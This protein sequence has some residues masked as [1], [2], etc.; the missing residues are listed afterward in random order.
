MKSD[1]EIAQHAKMKKITTI[2][3][4]IGLKPSEIEMYG[5]YKAKISF[6]AINRKD[7]NSQGKIIL[8]SAINPTPAGEGKSTTTI[9]LGDSLSK[10]GYKTMIALREPSLG[11][12]MGVKGGAA[13]GGYAQVVPMEDINLHFTGD[14]HAITSA[15]NLI[16][17][18]IDNHMYHGNQLHINPEKIIWKRAM[19]MNDRALRRIEVGLSS[20]KEV[21]RFDAFDITVASEVM[22]VLCL[23]TDIEDLKTRLARMV[24]AYNT[25][26]EPITVGDLK[27]TGAVVMLLKDAVKPNLVQTLEN[28]PV[29]IH[30]GPFA[31]IAHGC[32]SIIATSFARSASDYV[33]TEAGFG[34]DLGMEKFID[35]KARTMNTMPSLVVL[36]VSIRALKLHGGVDKT[37]MKEENLT[38]LQKGIENLEKHVES[39]L[40]YHLP[41]V[42]ALNKFAS[43]TDNEVNLVMNWASFHD[44]PISLSEVFEKGSDGGLDLARKVIALTNKPSLE[45]SKP[46]YVLNSTIREKVSIIT[47]KIYGASKVEYS[48]KAIEQMKEYEDLGW[49]KLAICMA[50]TPL[51]LTDNPKILGRP[52]DFT[53]TVREFKPS[54]GAGF[55][56]ALTGDVMT[57][58]GLPKQGAYEFMDVIDHKIIGLF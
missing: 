40:E 29:L 49:D 5:S 55:L 31:N 4:K 18:V 15:N 1:L 38:A 39:V 27:V 3:K 41:Y 2:A 7:F 8:V 46:I 14:I 12:V 35:I 23:A 50:K 33:V 51:S 45:I 9:G 22:A 44:H 52:R 13:G 57:M 6:K 11:P 16:S 36:V 28:T 30:G 54:L 58:P 53:I 47:S 10:L 56:V 32:N 43:D 19:D 17:A 26:N 34:A 25:L 48:E 42:L 20:K 21:S 37:L 24:V